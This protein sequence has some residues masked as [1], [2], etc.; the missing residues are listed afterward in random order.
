MALK[1]IVYKSDSFVKEN[2]VL[3]QFNDEVCTWYEKSD[4]FTFK[5]SVENV[6]KIILNGDVYFKLDNC[7]AITNF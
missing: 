6:T 5:Y 3:S 1:Q 4:K 2:C 7:S